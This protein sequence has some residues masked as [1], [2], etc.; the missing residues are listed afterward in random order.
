[1]VFCQNER[2]GLY[3]LYDLLRVE[4]RFFGVVIEGEIYSACK[5][6]VYVFEVGEVSVLI[7]VIVGIN[8]VYFLCSD[9]AEL[10]VF[11]LVEMALKRYVFEEVHKEVKGLGF[12]EYKF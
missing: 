3:E 6:N 9:L 8:D 7:N 1:V 5:V 12:G 4:G 2:F 10:L 11:E